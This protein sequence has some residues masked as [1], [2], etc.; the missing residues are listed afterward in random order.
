[1]A[2]TRAEL[3]AVLSRPQR[4]LVTLALAGVPFVLTHTVVVHR[5]TQFGA[6]LI[7]FCVWMAWFVLVVAD[8]LGSPL[9]AEG[10]AGE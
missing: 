1:M 8:L 4:N 3:F 6:Y 5:V 10:T 9:D 2:T 7:A